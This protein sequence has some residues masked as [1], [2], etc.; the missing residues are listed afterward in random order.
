VNLLPKFACPLHRKTMTPSNKHALLYL[1][2]VLTAV[3]WG[4]TFIAGRIVAREMGPFSAA[5]LRFLVA[6]LILT[7]F[8]LRTHRTIPVLDRSQFLSI[9]ALA[10]TGVFSYNAFFFSGL[11]TVTASRAALIITSNPAF[12]AI[13]AAIFFGERL[14]FS[15]TLGILISISGAMIVISKGHPLQILEGN[16]GLGELYIC[17]CVLSW[18]AYSLIGKVA[19]SRLSALVSVTCSCV[20]GTLF[21]SLPAIS[22][23][24]WA[25]ITGSSL[26]GWISVLYL[27]FFGTSLGF[28]WYYEGIRAIGPSRAG[29]FINIVP[30]CAVILA[31]FILNEAIDAS[32][33]L[34]AT[35]VFAGVYLTNRTRISSLEPP[36]PCP[37]K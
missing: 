30:V 21:L 35:F 16:L 20:I 26:V 3:F 17:G 15:R 7:V 22:E 34:G 19:L 31:F 1:K 23:D 12:I 2:L 29:V 8:L 10:L 27:G 6:S 24:L 5:F 33:V 9:I 37:K 13:F 25:N 36:F 28:I 18:V 32:I 14:T 11:K 4:G